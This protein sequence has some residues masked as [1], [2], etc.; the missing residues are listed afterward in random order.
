MK[1]LI[2]DLNN[3]CR[4]RCERRSTIF[5]LW[6]FTE[7]S[8]RISCSY[9]LPIFCFFFLL[10]VLLPIQ[11]HLLLYHLSRSLPL[12]LCLMFLPTHSSIILQHSLKPLFLLMFHPIPFPLTTISL[13]PLAFAFFLFSRCSLLC[14]LLQTS[15]SDLKPI[16]PI[17]RLKICR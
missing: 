16:G 7:F 13:L 5:I 3:L 15:F 14:C 8:I 1:H 4:I 12:P 9:C 10:G 11:Y 17:Q 6:I 2:I